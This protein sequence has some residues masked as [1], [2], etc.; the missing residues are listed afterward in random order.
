METQDCKQRKQKNITAKKANQNKNIYKH[1]E[2][3]VK[4]NVYVI[5]AY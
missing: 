4:P 3:T 1:K 2:I 5:K